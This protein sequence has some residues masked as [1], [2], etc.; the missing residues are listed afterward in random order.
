MTFKENL[1][2]LPQV[3][4]KKLGCDFPIEKAY[5]C[6]LGRGL[7]LPKQLCGHF[8]HHWKTQDVSILKFE[9]LVSNT[10]LTHSIL[11]GH[12]WP[13]KLVI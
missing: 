2:H 11:Q 3:R 13:P 10:N 9:P 7:G 4:R 12:L 8:Q 5:L 1:K 6:Q